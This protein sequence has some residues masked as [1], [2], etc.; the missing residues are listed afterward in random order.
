MYENHCAE[1]VKVKHNSALSF[2]YIFNTPEFLNV[3]LDAMSVH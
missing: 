2:H 3:F 1:T